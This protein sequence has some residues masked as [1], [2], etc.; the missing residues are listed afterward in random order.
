MGLRM[1]PLIRG[2]DIHGDDG[3]VDGLVARTSVRTS[4]ADVTD[5]LTVHIASA[6][7]NAQEQER[8][9]LACR[10]RIGGQGYHITQPPKTKPPARRPPPRTQH[11]RVRH[12][13]VRE[14]REIRKRTG[15]IAAR[16]SA[17][18]STGSRATVWGARA[19]NHT[20]RASSFSSC[21]VDHPQ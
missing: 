6:A 8:A 13:Q 19:R 14:L 20:P 18:S 1:C 10:R 15:R 9:L 11:R 4:P 3:R 21:A 17:S 7:G 5:S 2:F 12:G 16:S